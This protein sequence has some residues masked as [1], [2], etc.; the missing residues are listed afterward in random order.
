MDADLQLLPSGTLVLQPGTELPKKIASALADTTARGLVVLA[1]EQLEQALPAGLSFW[2]GFGREFLISL[3][4]GSSAEWE[5]VPPPDWELFLAS[6]PLAPGMEYLSAE[7]LEK[8]W[9]ELNA[10][11]GRDRGCV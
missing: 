3:C 10:W 1:S 11:V 8:L 9:G 2:R 6:P 5:D 7:V 4:Q